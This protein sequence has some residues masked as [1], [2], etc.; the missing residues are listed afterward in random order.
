MKPKFKIG[1]VVYRVSDTLEKSFVVT[2]IHPFFEDEKMKKTIFYYY[3]IKSLY[4]NSGVADEKYLKERK[5]AI[6]Y[7]W[8]EFHET[9]I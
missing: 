5:D 7:I 6:V 2:K 8:K 9:Q 3:T 4:D 1:D